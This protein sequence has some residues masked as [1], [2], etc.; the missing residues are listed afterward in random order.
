MNTY[1]Q[2]WQQG[3][4]PGVWQDGWSWGGSPGWSLGLVE[5]TVEGSTARTP[6]RQPAGGGRRHRQGPLG[7]TRR[8]LWV[9]QHLRRPPPEV[10]AEAR[11][12]FRSSSDDSPRS[13]G[14]S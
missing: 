11:A 14:R 12:E 8:R 5:A 2:S 9:R 6:R 13:P 4:P 3:P 1:T 10:M 7:P